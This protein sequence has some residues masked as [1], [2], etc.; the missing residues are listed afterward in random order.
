MDYYLYL[1]TSDEKPMLCGIESFGHFYPYEGFDFLTDIAEKKPEL[2]EWMEVK[3]ER[4]IRYTIETFLGFFDGPS[5]KK[6]WKIRKR[7]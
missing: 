3:D 1:K 7:S 4:G 2:L 5:T 6:G